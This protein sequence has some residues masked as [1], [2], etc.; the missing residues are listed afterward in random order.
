MAVM[1]NTSDDNVW[2]LV[3]IAQ[4][5]NRPDL[6]RWNLTANNKKPQNYF[7]RK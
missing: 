1:V 7:Q 6:A 2:Y 4:W 5:S 3:Y